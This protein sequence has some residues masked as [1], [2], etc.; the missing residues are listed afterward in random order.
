MQTDRANFSEN[1]GILVASESDFT[2]K[3]IQYPDGMSHWDQVNSYLKLRKE[4]F[5]DRLEWPLFHAD[6]LEFEQYD[7]FDTT[8]VVASQGSKV[9]GGAR[10]RRTDQSGN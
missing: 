7:S 5:I 3:I 10:L 2:V 4:V 8:Y 6:D 9:V 1:S